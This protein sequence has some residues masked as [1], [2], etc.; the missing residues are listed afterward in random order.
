LR[1]AYGEGVALTVVIPVVAFLF[2]LVNLRELLFLIFLLSGSWTIFSSFVF[3]AQGERIYYL[4]WG[5]VLACISTAFVILIQFSIALILVAV[6]AL[7]FVNASTR[8][9]NRRDEQRLAGA[10][11]TIEGERSKGLVATD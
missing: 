7:I 2:N 6:V 1:L 10:Q 3:T 8:R 9:R 4:S 5:L 11:R